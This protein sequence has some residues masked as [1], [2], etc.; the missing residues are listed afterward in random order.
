MLK[1]Q[2]LGPG[3]PRCSQLAELTMRAAYELNLQCHVEKVTDMQKI[4][5]YGVLMTPALVID[6]QVKL[7]GKVPP[8]EDL[9]QLLAKE[10][11]Q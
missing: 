11:A 8:L 9:K 5:S 6:G 1:I 7:S 4:S 2:V 3:C 10:S